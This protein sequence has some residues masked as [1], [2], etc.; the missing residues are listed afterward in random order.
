MKTTDAVL[1]KLLGALIYADNNFENENDNDSQEFEFDY[2]IVDVTAPSGTGLK[3]TFISWLYTKSFLSPLLLRYILDKNGQLRIRQLAGCKPYIQALPPT[4]YPVH[5][6]SRDQMQMAQHWNSQHYNDHLL[7]SSDNDENNN[8]AAN[9]DDDDVVSATEVKSHS[10]DSN[11]NYRSIADY[12]QLYHSKKATSISLEQAKL[13]DARWKSGQQLSIFDGVPIALKD[14]S[15]VAGLSICDGSSECLE[16]NFDD[17]PAEYLQAA[18]AIVVGLT[19]MTEGGV[20]PLGYNAHARH[21]GPY[22]PHHTDYYC[23]GSSGGS[24]VAVAAGVTPMSVGWDGG[25]SIRI[26]AAMSGVIGLA[27][28]FGRI[29]FE[30]SNTATNIKA[31]PLASCMEDIALSYLLLGQVYITNAQTVT[32]QT[33]TGGQ[34]RRKKVFYNDLFGEAYLP[35]P[36]LIGVNN[37]IDSIASL[38]S[39]QATVSASSSQVTPTTV[40]VLKGIRLGI[41]WDHFQHTDPLIY[42]HCL[43]VV[44]FLQS[45]SIGATI[46]NITIPFLR[47]IQMSH[48][49]K[50]MSEFGLSWET[51]FYNTSY[52]IE[53]NT[54]ITIKLGRTVTADEILAAE[55]MRTFTIR[56]VRDLLFERL[57]LAAILSPVMGDRTP[58]TPPYVTMANFV[59]L[60][61]LSIPIGY[62]NPDDASEN[63]NENDLKENNTSTLLPIGF[64]MMGDAWNE[65]KL[66][67]LG[68]IIEQLYLPTQYHGSSNSHG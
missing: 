10:S 67:Q 8:D 55:K 7:L 31:G 52:H 42:Q 19:I 62:Y 44:E 57:Q 30:R 46:V 64:Q 60:P 26:P 58:K 13:S 1:T 35:P 47:E 14:Q 6:A 36:H 3:L 22:N 41:F 21:N 18:G 11:S 2:N 39:S 63:E 24:A 66:I 45:P 20:T 16:T 9:G 25:G 68:Y 61:A 43:D 50:I 48:G 29:P 65:H 32:P 54:D 51:K 17:I 37:I 28:T 23:G 27:P 4:H 40:P 59:G 5:Q 53:A 56:Y 12:Y 33:S 38:K 49:I 34:R 15:P